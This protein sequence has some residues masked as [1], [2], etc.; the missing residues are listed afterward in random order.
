MTYTVKT[1]HSHNMLLTDFHV[2]GFFKGGVATTL[3]QPLD[4]LKTRAMNAKPG[5]FNSLWHLALYTAK[6][7]PLG[8]FKVCYC[9]MFVWKILCLA[10]YRWLIWINVNIHSCNPWSWSS[11]V[12][13]HYIML[14]DSSDIT[15]SCSRKFC[16]VY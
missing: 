1:W 10:L 16:F 8:F 14:L 15:A 2:F 9:F 12:R 7:G 5:E 13:S 3:T 4:V 6:L 11:A